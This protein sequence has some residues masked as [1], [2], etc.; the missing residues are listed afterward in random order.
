MDEKRLWVTA[1]H[2]PQREVLV[3][4][5]PGWTEEMIFDFNQHLEPRQLTHGDLAEAR[6]SGAV[7]HFYSIPNPF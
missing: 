6:A 5:H 7:P 2:T 1:Y 3:T 4:K